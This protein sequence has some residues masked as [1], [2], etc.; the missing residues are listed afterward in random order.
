[1]LARTHI[2]AAVFFTLLLFSDSPNIFLFLPV[3]IL[4][5]LLPDADTRFS[6]IGKWKIFRIFNFFVKHRG[7]S[8]S[9]IFLFAISCL[10]FVLF[11]EILLPFI[12]GYSLHLFLDCLTIQGMRLF[13][14]SKLKIRGFIKTGRTAEFLVFI[15]FFAGSLFLILNKFFTIL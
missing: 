11:R 7:I 9:L 4:A 12:L 5:S 6:K 15:I 2:A 3:S 13:Y 8:H 10:T 14:P 1:M